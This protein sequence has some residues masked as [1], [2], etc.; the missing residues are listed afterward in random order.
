MLKESKFVNILCSLLLGM[1]AGT[2]IL[3]A[4]ALFGGDTDLNRTRLTLITD[5]AEKLYD[6]HPLT[7][8]GWQLSGDLKPGH[9]ASVETEG[10]RTN[11][12]E[13]ENKATLTILD[14]AGEDVTSEYKIKYEFGLLTVTPRSLIVQ[15]I[16]VLYHP[17]CQNGV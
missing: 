1:V 6:A 3:L 12:G 8:D 17:I 14:E 4:V 13:S 10:S 11:A 7:A 2:C 9:T 5:S 16:K 15:R